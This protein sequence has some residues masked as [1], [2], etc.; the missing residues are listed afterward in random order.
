MKT[1]YS[2][3]SNDARIIFCEMVDKLAKKYDYPE[4]LEI[5]AQINGVEVDFLAVVE[6]FA[7]SLDNMAAAK[8]KEKALDSLE[9][10]ELECQRMQELMFH[11]KQE[12]ESTVNRLFK[13]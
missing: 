4:E 13:L 12:L 2:K 5:T 7:Q 1:T 6:A 3:L 9:N 11:A 8:A 10:I